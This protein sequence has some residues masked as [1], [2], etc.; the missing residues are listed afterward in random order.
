MFGTKI[1]H[2]NGTWFTSKTPV[3][4]D[5]GRDAD[6]QW[7]PSWPDW[8]DDPAHLAGRSEDEDPVGSHGP[9]SIWVARSKM[10]AISLA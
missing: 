8:M 5:P 9:P 2:P 4:R 6:P 10:V 1:I 3:P 7:E